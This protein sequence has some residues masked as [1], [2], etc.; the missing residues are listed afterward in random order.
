M[1]TKPELSFCQ[2]WNIVRRPPRH[3][4]RFLAAECRRQ[5]HFPD[6]RRQLEGDPHPLGGGAA[7]N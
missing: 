6:T 5:P 2:I 7:C 3:S 4:I 1:S